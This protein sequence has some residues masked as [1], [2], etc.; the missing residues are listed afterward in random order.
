M[1]RIESRSLEQAVET[2]IRVA[3]LEKLQERG[4]IPLIRAARHS[5]FELAMIGSDGAKKLEQALL[6]N[7]GPELPYVRGDVFC[8]ED[9]AHFLIFGDGERGDVGGVRAG[10][11][12]RAGVEDAALH[13]DSFCRHVGDALDA[14][15]ATT[16]HNHDAHSGGSA[17]PPHAASWL[18]H[19]PRVSDSFLRFAAAQD[20]DTSAAFARGEMVAGWLRAVGMLENLEARRVLRR[21]A[22]AHREGHG[23]SLSI[24]G[25]E[26][27]G[28][29]ESQLS[30]L[31][32]VGLIRR[33]ILV[34]CRRDGRALFRLPSPDAFSVLSASHAMCSECGSMLADEKA[35]EI[36]VPTSLTSTLLQDGTWLT[37]H[38]RSIL[39]RLGIPENQVATHSIS[40]DGELQ[41]MTDVAGEPFLFLLRDGDWALPHVRGV[42][43]EYAG[44]DIAHL[45]IIAT[46]RIHD[47]A[48]QR[49]REYGRRHGGRGRE[50]EVL[51][52]EGMDA[53]A[54]GLSEAFARIAERA[55]AEELWELDPSLGFS[56]GRMLAARFRL[57]WRPS[58]ISPDAA[59][60]AAFGAPA[61]G[62]LRAF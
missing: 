7:S 8:F 2:A 9:F 12:H 27:E 21:L 41:M 37:S 55:L 34:S 4:L 43:G 39:V 1:L 53:V 35:E 54:S 38:L 20:G 6:R 45:V 10:I 5:L 51:L 14:A 30:K 25:D 15:C 36:A 58:N 28:L 49:L 50:T 47:D 26:R 62:G 59:E 48:R 33:E 46:G 24:A 42:F 32:E 29:S 40:D 13:L 18:K 56:A 3:V 44:A 52:I 17:S 19:E 11:I 22:E 23:A 16:Q 61:G 57:L 31:A 60:A